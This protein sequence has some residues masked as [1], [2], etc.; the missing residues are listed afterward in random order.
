MS[1]VFRFRIAENGS[2]DLDRWL[3]LRT[4]LYL[5]SGLIDSNE[6]DDAAGMYVDEYDDYSTHLLASDDAGVD[7]GC[8]R[9][10]E[11]QDDQTLPVTDLFGIE[12]LPRSYEGSGVAVAPQHRKEL[13]SL[14]LYRAISE[15]ADQ[16]GY[17]YSYSII[18]EP[19]VAA[20]RRLGYPIEVLS[21]PRF[22]FNAPNVAA[23]IDRN[24]MLASMESSDSALSSLVQR[25]YR[26]PFEWSLAESDLAS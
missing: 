9:I 14:G 7:I 1:D 8:C 13:V 18:E 17:E 26:K 24:E 6:V 21:E 10:I 19:A 5:E 15:L 3:D 12:P 23:V 16:K 25:Y 22:V 11:P 20:L 2:P 4:T